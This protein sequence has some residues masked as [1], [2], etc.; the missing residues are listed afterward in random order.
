MRDGVGAGSRYRR[1]TIT[2]YDGNTNFRSPPH[3]GFAVVVKDQGSFDDESGNQQ[4]NARTTYYN[5]PG[6]SPGSYA[7][8][9]YGRVTSITDP[10]RKASTIAYAPDFV[11]FVVAERSALEHERRTA[12]FGVDGESTAGGVFGAVKWTLDPN[13]VGKPDETS[14]RT[15]YTYDKLGRLESVQRPL[16]TGPTILFSYILS[17][18]TNHRV[19]T[20]RRLDAV[21]WSYF[22]RI[23]PFGDDRRPG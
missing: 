3:E 19:Q 6:A 17:A 5:S 4:W 2:W 18:G 8:D 9:T 21:S 14:Y 7:R 10:N 15:S 11:T 12:Y 13:G 20:R 1:N 23:R 16:D 22:R